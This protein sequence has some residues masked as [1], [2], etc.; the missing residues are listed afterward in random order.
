LFALAGPRQAIFLVRY[1]AI[2]RGDQ[3]GMCL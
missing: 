3:P 1:L 2:F